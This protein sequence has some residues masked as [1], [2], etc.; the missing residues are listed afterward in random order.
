MPGR[1]R[2]VGVGVAA[3]AQPSSMPVRT[4]SS[5]AG[6]ESV[7]CGMLGAPAPSGEKDARPRRSITRPATRALSRTT[8]TL[9]AS[10]ASSSANR[11]ATQPVATTSGS[12]GCDA[13]RRTALRALA[14]ASPVTAQVFTTI[15]SA[16]HSSARR[17]PAR[18][19][20]E[21][22]RSSSTRLTRHPRL[23]R[24]TAGAAGVVTC[25]S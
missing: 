2:P 9:G 21:A 15:A 12:P 4:E 23:T 19:S 22:M 24:A 5:P 8:T 6:A 3:A 18:S 16:S 25:G 11:L 13:A 1:V 14:S 10:A 20:S 17:A 7:L